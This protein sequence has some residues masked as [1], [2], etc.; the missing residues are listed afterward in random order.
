MF[1]TGTFLVIPSIHP[2]QSRIRCKG[3]PKQSQTVDVIPLGTNDLSGLEDDT[4]DRLWEAGMDKRLRFR[5]F[6][7]ICHFK[8]RI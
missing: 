3:S 1:H 8:F 6:T 4:L 5:M 7:F 2:K